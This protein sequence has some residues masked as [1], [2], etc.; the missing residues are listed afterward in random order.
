MKIYM[1]FANISLNSVLCEAYN[2]DQRMH[3]VP[4]S[5]NQGICRKSINLLR[6]CILRDL[7][8]IILHKN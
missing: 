6:S 7:N 5:L 2:S 3:N 1:Y 8:I 4:A